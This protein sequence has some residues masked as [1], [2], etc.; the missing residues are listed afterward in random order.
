MLDIKFTKKRFKDHMYYSKWAYIAAILGAA[1]LFSIVFTVTK[2][3][4]PN[5]LKVD[6]TVIGVTLQEP[7]KNMWQ[8]EILETLSEDQQE[9][10]I[11]ALGFSGSDGSSMDYTMFE[12]LAARIAAKEDDILILSKD[13]Y[14]TYASQGAFYS[15]DEI[16]GKYDFPED[17]YDLEEYKT[18]TDEDTESHLYGI[19]ISHLEGFVDLGVDPTDKVMAV[20]IYTENYDNVLKTIDYMMG[21]T[22]SILLS[23]MPIETEE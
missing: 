16:V 10:N 4:V 11:Y 13:V 14:L 2:P 9:V 20:L 21:K 22:D 5:E 6:V 15:M 17:M 12:V 23:Q 19:P 8:K 1:A 3:K 7:E 18:T